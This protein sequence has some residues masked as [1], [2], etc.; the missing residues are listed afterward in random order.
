MIFSLS[1]IVS[2]ECG[3]K[4]PQIIIIG[5]NTNGQA[6]IK[7][8]GKKGRDIIILPANKPHK[9]YGHSQMMFY[10]MMMPFGYYSL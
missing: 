5:A 9:H 1:L 4:K 6:V 10:P 7:A 2:I 3:K 8:G